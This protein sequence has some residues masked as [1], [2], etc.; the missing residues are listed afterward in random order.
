MSPLRLPKVASN[1]FQANGDK[2][3]VIKTEKKYFYMGAARTLT[4]WVSSML[5]AP[6]RNKKNTFCSGRCAVAGFGCKMSPLRLP[7][8]AS[9]RFLANGDKISVIKTEKKYFYMGAAR[10]LTQWVRSM[11]GAPLENKENTFCSG[12]CAIVGFGCKTS[13]LRLPKVASNRFLANGGKIS[14]IKTEKKYFYMGA[15][16]TQTLWVSSM[17]GAPWR[18]NKNTFCS[19]RCAVVGFCCKTAPLR[20]PK[21]ASNRFLAIGDQNKGEKTGKK[22]M[23]PVAAR[24]Q[25]LWVGSML[26]ESGP[27]EQNTFCSDR[28][29]VVQFGCKMAPLRLPKIASNRLLT[30]G[31]KIKVVKTGKK[32]FSLGDARTVTRWVRSRL[33]VPLGNKKIL[34]VR[35]GVPFSDFAVKWLPCG[36]QKLHPTVF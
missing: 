35:A 14:V 32:Y 4:L 12:R 20:L 3:K 13:P 5:G 23:F 17:L 27:K 16:R 26:S 9:N 1:R 30:N 7:K 28:C 18:N 33:G 24:T 36:C 8:V 22:Y 21:V 11:L 29:A 25:T 31:D 15:A 19:G 2:I 34:S 6:W 10:T